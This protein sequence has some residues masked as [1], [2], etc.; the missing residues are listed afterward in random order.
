M[1]IIYKKVL[2]V[3]F[4]FFIGK[5]KVFWVLFWVLEKRKGMK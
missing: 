4:F 2:F 3:F 1:Q 5:I